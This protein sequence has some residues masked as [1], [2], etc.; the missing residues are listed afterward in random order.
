METAY[1]IFWSLQYSN[2]RF[3]EGDT[4]GILRAKTVD[5]R[6]I[7]GVDAIRTVGVEKTLI[8]RQS[9]ADKAALG[10]E[11]LVGSRE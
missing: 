2:Q 9:V 8:F 7:E 1:Q 6:S 11:F 10:K 5:G 3:H 4:E